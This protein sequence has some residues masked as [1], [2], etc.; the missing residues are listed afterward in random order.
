MV[1]DNLLLLIEWYA[2]DLLRHVTD[3][4]EHELGVDIEIMAIAKRNRSLPFRFFIQRVLV[5]CD[6]F[7]PVIAINIDFFR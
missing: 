7:K 5:K 2:W 4:L 6:T 1:K 3:A